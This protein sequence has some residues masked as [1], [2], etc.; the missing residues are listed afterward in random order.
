MKKSQKSIKIL[1]AAVVFAVI[2]FLL[3]QNN[4]DKNYDTRA[5]AFTG[6]SSAQKI[7]QKSSDSGKAGTMIVEIAAG[8]E[9]K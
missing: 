8:I 2:G 9:Q 7:S 1:S 4:Q 5:D 6:R 3:W